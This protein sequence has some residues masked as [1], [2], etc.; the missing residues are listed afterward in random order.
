MAGNGGKP[1]FWHF[2]TGF[3]IVA[4]GAVFALLLS[5]FA[6]MRSELTR[7]DERQTGL[8]S[9]FEEIGEELIR[10][11]QQISGLSANLAIANNTSASQDATH[12]SRI[13]NIEAQITRI[14]DV[15]QPNV[16]IGPRRYDISE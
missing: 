11:R 8:H 10:L 6:N 1:T 15:L 4:G 2:W 7:I 12:Q 3:S 13:N 16:Q 9:E 5:Y 14:V